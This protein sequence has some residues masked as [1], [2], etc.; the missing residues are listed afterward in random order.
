M[1]IPVTG[2]VNHKVVRSGLSVAILRPYRWR[3]RYLSSGCSRPSFLSSWA[4]IN[5]SLWRQRSKI[6]QQLAA[7][8]L[9]RRGLENHRAFRSTLFLYLAEKPVGEP[10][11]ASIHWRS[12]TGSRNRGEHSGERAAVP[13]VLPRPHAR[14]REF[15][16]SAR[17]LYC[18][19]HIRIHT[20][21]QE[22]M[23]PSVHAPTSR[24]PIVKVNSRS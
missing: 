11:L 1:D 13:A 16:C 15:R 18:T 8:R 12:H 2:L 3:S 9:S 4:W 24:W 20:P 19:L 23:W 21:P 14:Y 7:C 22:H 5:T 17:P 10:F 6:N